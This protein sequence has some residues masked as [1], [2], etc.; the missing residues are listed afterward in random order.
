MSPDQNL[1][2]FNFIYNKLGINIINMKIK[3]NS[4]G[5]DKDSKDT[6]VVVAMSEGLIPPVAGIMK[7]GY[8]VI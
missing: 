1:K 8:D 4:I 2:S 6:T 7:E 3:L 5:L